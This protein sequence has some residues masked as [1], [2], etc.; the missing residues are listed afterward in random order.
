[1]YGAQS[2]PQMPVASTLSKASLSSTEGTSNS[3]TWISRGFLS[4]AA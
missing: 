2:L 3:R 1:M 4:T